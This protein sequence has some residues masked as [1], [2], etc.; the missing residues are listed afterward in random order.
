MISVV[1]HNMVLLLVIHTVRY[2]VHI[3]KIYAAQ[4]RMLILICKT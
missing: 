2:I 1:Y 3:A 4:L